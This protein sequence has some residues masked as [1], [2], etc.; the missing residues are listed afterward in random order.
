MIKNE[1]TT[2]LRDEHSKSSSCIFPIK[3]PILLFLDHQDF[4]CNYR[5]ET[6]PNSRMCLSSL[7]PRTSAV[8]EVPSSALAGVKSSLLQWIFQRRY[9]EI[10]NCYNLCKSRT[11]WSHFLG[12]ITTEGLMRVNI[13]LLFSETLKY[14]LSMRSNTTESACSRSMTSPLN[15]LGA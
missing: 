5:I 15:P 10:T 7:L 6:S 2:H 1:P 13:S 11:G 4:C 14:S 9:P 12:L 8:R 3:V